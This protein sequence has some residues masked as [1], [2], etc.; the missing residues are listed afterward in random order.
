MQYQFY[1]SKMS[2]LYL[3]LYS[4]IDRNIKMSRT[5]HFNGLSQYYVT[6]CWV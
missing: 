3:S 6:Y 4:L 2:Q 5:L 1:N